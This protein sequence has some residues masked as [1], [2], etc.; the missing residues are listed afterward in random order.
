MN[1][2]PSFREPRRRS[3]QSF[4]SQELL[5]S[6][7]LS[8]EAITLRADSGDPEEAAARAASR[9]TMRGVTTVT[10]AKIMTLKKLKSM[11]KYHIGV[12]GP[13]KEDEEEAG[14]EE[15]KRVKI[16]GL[17]VKVRRK[18]VMPID[19]AVLPRINLTS[20][21]RKNTV[22]TPHEKHAIGKF[23]TLDSKWK[24]TIDGEVEKF[25][26]P[27]LRLEPLYAQEEPTPDEDATTDETLDDKA[28]P[29][30]RTIDEVLANTSKVSW[31]LE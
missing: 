11:R 30:P 4:R 1:N 7:T 15:E 24:A 28:M 5:N 29:S 2:A 19:P 9:R 10:H 14:E 17:S 26:Y 8:A 18:S 23:E 6:L 20:P 3:R 22:K 12:H 21:T 16:E 31:E 13:L 27:S 25:M